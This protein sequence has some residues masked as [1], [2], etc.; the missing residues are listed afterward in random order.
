MH[1][2]RAHSHIPTHS[3]L[4]THARAHLHAHIHPT[5][6]T[7]AHTNLHAR[8]HLH[9]TYCIREHTYA[10]MRTPTLEPTAP[11]RTRTQTSI[12]TDS[13]P[14]RSSL[15][16]RAS[17]SRCCPTGSGWRRKRRRW[18][19][20]ETASRRRRPRERPSYDAASPNCRRRSPG[21]NGRRRIWPRNAAI[22]GRR[23]RR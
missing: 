16:W 2:T 6:C 20:K 9:T 21:K 23:C 17:E 7:R 5:Y 13:W 3:N 22:C 19:R 10:R 4:N 12:R 14:T 11:A 18:R 8:S 1:N 15:V